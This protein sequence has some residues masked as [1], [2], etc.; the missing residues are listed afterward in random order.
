MNSGNNPL[1]IGPARSFRG[2]AV[3]R[4]RALLASA[5]VGT[6][7]LTRSFQADRDPR[8]RGP[9]PLNSNR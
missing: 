4:L 9:R 1:N 6:R 8:E 3:R 7:A 5:P 2:G